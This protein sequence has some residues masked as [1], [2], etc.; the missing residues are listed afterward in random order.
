M[1]GFIEVTNSDDGMK[2]LV[3]VRRITAIVRDGNGDVYIEMGTNG[4]MVSSGILVEE[5]F[6]QVKRKIEDSEA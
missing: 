4:E 3:P 2:V 6:E 5:D 1:K